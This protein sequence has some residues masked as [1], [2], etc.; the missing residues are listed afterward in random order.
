MTERGAGRLEE[1]AAMGMSASSLQILSK[2]LNRMP[3]I[4]VPRGKKIQ[5]YLAA[6]YQLPDYANH[7]MPDDF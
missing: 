2:F 7:K 6:N 3:T 1:G 5:V 4:T